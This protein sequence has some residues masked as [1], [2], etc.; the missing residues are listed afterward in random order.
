MG[1]RREDLVLSRALGGKNKDDRKGLFANKNESW[2]TS[3]KNFG[4]ENRN[5]KSQEAC[6]DRQLVQVKDETVQTTLES[7]EVEN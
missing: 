6:N 1:K 7:K 3:K 4:R 2:G 5:A